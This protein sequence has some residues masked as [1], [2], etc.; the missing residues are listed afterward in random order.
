MACC[1]MAP[2]YYHDQWWLIV[3]EVLW[4]MFDG[5][6]FWISP[7]LKLHPHF[8]VANELTLIRLWPSR[9]NTTLEAGAHWIC[10]M[11]YGSILG[12]KRVHSRH[13][14]ISSARC[15][16]RMAPPPG[17]LPTHCDLCHWPAIYWSGL[18][19]TLCHLIW[20]VTWKNLELLGEGSLWTSC[21]AWD[22]TR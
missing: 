6:C 5:N 7:H 19:N 11:Q 12:W 16:R 8:L 14:R 22:F 20:L 17:L 4:Q 1:L 3:S 9:P 13:M 10:P 2:I 15:N 21:L 18:P